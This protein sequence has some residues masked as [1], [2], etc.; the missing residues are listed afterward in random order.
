[1][2]LITIAELSNDLNGGWVKRQGLFSRCALNVSTDVFRKLV[3]RTK[4]LGFIQ[5]RRTGK[6]LHEVSLTPDGARLI[7]RAYELI[8]NINPPIL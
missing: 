4:E 2:I 5:T 1:M 6:T 3:W 8:A 7:Q